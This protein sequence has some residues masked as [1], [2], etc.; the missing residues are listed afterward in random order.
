MGKKPI[1]YWN[2]LAMRAAFDGEALTELYEYFFPRVYNFIYARLKQRA[3]ADDAVSE[4]FVKAV[5]HLS[6]YDGERAAFS[7]WLFRIA[8]NTMHSSLR[9]APVR[10]APWE[11]FFNPAAPAHE[12]PEARAVAAEN[13][14]RLLKALDGLEERQRRI[15]ELKYWGDLGNKEIAEVLGLGAAHVGVLHFRALGRL[16]QLLSEE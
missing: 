7:T 2:Q 1:S 15:M 5:A 11:E 12:E 9:G 10:E 3:Q 13:Q 6:E 14:Q 8:V 16:Q 4:T